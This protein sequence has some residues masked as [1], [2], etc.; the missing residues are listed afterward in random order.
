M[1]ASAVVIPGR[2]WRTP[3]KGFPAWLAARVRGE[4]EIIRGIT[5]AATEA[6]VDEILGRGGLHRL[7]SRAPPPAAAT[8][9]SRGGDAG[10]G[11]GRRAGP[12]PDARK[13]E[14]REAT[15]AGPNR[16]RSAD[17][18]VADHALHHAP[19]E[20]VLDLLDQLRHGTPVR[21]VR[22]HRRRGRRTGRV[23]LASRL[24]V[25][26]TMVAGIKAGDVG[27][28]TAGRRWCLENGGG[29]GGSGGG[30]AGDPFLAVSAGGGGAVVGAGSTAGA[31]PPVI[32][33]AGALGGGR[34]HRGRTVRSLDL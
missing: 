22:R 13:V 34:P 19:R 15:G 18:I 26:I 30:S 5:A 28:I 6:G 25:P 11:R 7:A 21:L 9:G 10:V 2:R 14:D 3:V 32:A 33:G 24:V 4:V 1:R 16:S 12:L 31:G 17:H 29:G 20:L 27:G 23:G 8:V